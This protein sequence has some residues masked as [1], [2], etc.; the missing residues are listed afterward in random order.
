MDRET[1]HQ[2][3]MTA[4]YNKILQPGLGFSDIWTMASPLE[5]VAVLLGNF[6]YQVENGGLGQYVDNNYAHRPSAATLP[7]MAVAAVLRAGAVHN[8]AVAEAGLGMLRHIHEEPKF[9]DDEPYLVPDMDSD[10]G[11]IEEPGLDAESKRAGWYTGLDSGWC[12]FR[13][14]D[15]EAF[16]QAVLDSWPAGQDP[17]ALAL[18]AA[19]GPSLF[20]IPATPAFG[21]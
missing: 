15:R 10:T 12:G 13:Q 1:S 5:R 8:P 6:N 16:M 19:K 17:F 14:A 7:Y 9:E 18:E 20:E 4:A 11:M 2:S 21:R 3:L